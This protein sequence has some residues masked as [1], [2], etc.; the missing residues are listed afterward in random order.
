MSYTHLS[1]EERHYIEIERKKGVSMNRIGKS[2]DRGQSTISREIKRNTGLRNY[3]HNQANHL[4]SQ[5]HHE[6]PKAMKLTDKIKKMING[7]L[8]Q[9]WSPEQIAGRLKH[10]AIISLHHE[11]IYQYVLADK[12]NGGK[13]Y[14]HLR[15]QT[16]KYRKRYGSSRTSNSAGIPDRIDIDQR[17][18]AADNRERLGDWEADTIIGKNH[19]GAIVTL[20]ERVSKLRLAAPLQGKKAAPLTDAV[21]AILKP[22]KK[23]VLTIAFQINIFDFLKLHYATFNLL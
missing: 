23:F 10:D 21:I 7:Y 2:L 20:D 15:H 19:Q 1:L 16:K 18:A 22:I 4:A 8:E 5:R 14:L 9:D 12:A 17:P 6:K 13:L 11:T 3:R